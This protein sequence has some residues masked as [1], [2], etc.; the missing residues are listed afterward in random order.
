MVDTESI[1]AEP[2]PLSPVETAGEILAS[3][4]KGWDLTLEE[5]AE[6]LNLGVDVI[7]ALE[8]NEY[9]DLPGATFVKGYLRSYANLLRLNPEEVIATVDIQPEKLP[10]IL[11]SRRTVKLKVKTRVRKRSKSRSFL[12][13]LMFLI[14][15]FVLVL[16]GLN[17]WSRL[18]L[19]TQ[20]LAELFKLPSGESDSG[21]RDENEIVFPNED[22]TGSGGNEPKQALIRI[23]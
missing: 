6:N 5:V 9:G 10:D 11:S 20:G 8:R 3:A 21:S 2:Q 4:R 17:Q 15:F 14:L 13:G 12:K 7:R 23:E 18:D 22:D 16:F 1:H 19:D